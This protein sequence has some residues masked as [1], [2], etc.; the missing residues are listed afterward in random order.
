MSPDV[1]REALEIAR[2]FHRFSRHFDHC[3]DR[4]MHAAAIEMRHGMRS[5]RDGGGLARKRRDS[6]GQW[7]L[8]RAESHDSNNR[9]YGR[10]L[11]LMNGPV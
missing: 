4:V 7:R 11:R 10:C 5:D 3:G 1:S 9:H 6:P 2:F 8:I